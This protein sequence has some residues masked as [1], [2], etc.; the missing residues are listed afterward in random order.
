MNE[1]A[2]RLVNIVKA[3]EPSKVIKRKDGKE[4]GQIAVTVDGTW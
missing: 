3:E 1:V 4:V 2:A